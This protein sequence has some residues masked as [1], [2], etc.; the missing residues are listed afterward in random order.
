MYQAISDK[1]FDG[2]KPLF[3]ISRNLGTLAS[4]LLL[5]LAVDLL[6]TTLSFP[7]KRRVHC[8]LYPFTSKA[9][10]LANW[11]SRRGIVASIG[12]VLLHRS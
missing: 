2:E 10:G 6:S 4:Q 5:C 12:L 9:T 8:M 11:E 7:E 3:P 1:V